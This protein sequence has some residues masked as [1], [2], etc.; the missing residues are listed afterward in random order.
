MK[1]EQFLECFIDILKNDQVK[2]LLSNIFSEKIVAPLQ[3]KIDK[4]QLELKDR[5]LHIEHLED[6]M[7]CQKQKITSMQRRLDN[8]EKEQKEKNLIIDGVPETNNEI[9]ETKLQKIFKDKMG[10]EIAEKDIVNCHRLGRKP[11][12]LTQKR[13]KIIVTFKNSSIKEKVN[14]NKN[15]LKPQNEEE[16]QEVYINEDMPSE[17]TEVFFKLRQEKNKQRIN[18]VWIYKSKI[19]AKLFN[20]D[21]P[22]IIED[23]ADYTRFMKWAEVERRRSSLSENSV[24]SRD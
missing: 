20:K 11:E 18:A 22:Q 2:E 17:K 15:K 23:M 14:R 13:R 24:G 1:K 8:L 7:E 3:E 19:H 9:L 5:E 21:R 6:T 12:N 10:L 16:T 4:L